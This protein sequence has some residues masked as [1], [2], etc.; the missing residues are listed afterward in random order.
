VAERSFFAG[1]VDHPARHLSKRCHP[2]LVK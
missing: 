2:C 1:K